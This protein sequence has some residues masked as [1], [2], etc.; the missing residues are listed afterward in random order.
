MKLLHTAMLIAAALVQTQGFADFLSVNLE[1]RF[2]Y[3]D[4]DKSCVLQD[5]W[6]YLKLTGT[7]DG[8]AVTEAI[9]HDTNLTFSKQIEF[10]P[11]ELKGLKIKKGPLGDY[12][13]TQMVLNS[14]LLNWIFF[15][16]DGVDLNSPVFCRPPQP[17]ATLQ[18]Q[19]HV[20]LFSQKDAVTYYS[21]SQRFEGQ[22]EDRTP[23]SVRLGF[24]QRQ[25]D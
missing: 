12:Y 14:R 8:D 11:E 4:L 7:V 6:K 24:S 3:Q 15:N 18:P 19:P 23:Y 10:L 9:L 25:T 17:L 21:P 2:S 13:V 20:F 1:P 5:M 22:R 16:M